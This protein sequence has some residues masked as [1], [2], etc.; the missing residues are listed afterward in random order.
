[1]VQFSN[2]K[3][4]HY[5]NQIKSNTICYQKTRSIL[6][7]FLATYLNLCQLQQLVHLLII[8]G[9]LV[10]GLSLTHLEKIIIYTNRINTI[11]SFLSHIASKYYFTTVYFH[12]QSLP[13]RMYCISM[14]NLQ[15]KLE[16]LL[17]SGSQ[18]VLRVQ[19]HQPVPL[20]WYLQ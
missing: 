16:F 4:F 13:T 3:W 1:M 12:Q 10:G 7:L 19:F 2:L 9:F 5:I 8:L 20:I 17:V 18:V 11:A 6:V 14:F 15:I